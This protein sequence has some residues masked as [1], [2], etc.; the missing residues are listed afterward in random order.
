MNRIKRSIPASV[1][2]W[3]FCRNWGGW[4]AGREI[5]F[6]RGREEYS[7][8]ESRLGGPS[9]LNIIEIISISPFAWKRGCF[10]RSSAKMQPTDHM[11]TA[12]EY[13]V[14]PSRISGALERTILSTLNTLHTR[15]KTYR[16]HNVT[17]S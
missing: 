11:S 9:N 6:A 2:N 3:N 1:M 16:Y 14:A 4:G 17:T 15:W 12:V 8:Q 13:V 5:V 7:G 10:R